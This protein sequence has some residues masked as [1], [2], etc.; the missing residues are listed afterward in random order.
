MR[1]NLSK[2]II[3]LSLLSFSLLLL[4]IFNSCDDT[5]SPDDS[6]FSFVITV[7][8]LN[9]NPIEGIR[10]AAWNYLKLSDGFIIGKRRHIKTKSSATTTIRY[11]LKINSLVSLTIFD[12]ENQVIARLHDE[13]KLIAGL[14]EYN[15]QITVPDPI[16]FYKCIYVAR[17]DTTKE[18]LFSDSI[19]ITLYQPD[20]YASYIGW[21]SSTG[22][23]KTNNIILFP[24]LTKEFKSV[25]HTNQNSYEPLGYAT[26]LDSIRIVLV[27]TISSKWQNVVRNI[28]NGRNE[29]DVIWNP[30]D[31]LPNSVN[32]INE[33]IQS[34]HF[35]RVSKV[36]GVV[37]D[38]PWALYQ[39]YP[40]PY[41]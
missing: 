30:K 8:D 2:R 3:G 27:D 18:I 10:V 32:K 19:Y 39:N 28:H 26:F 14:H 9:G 24:S 40:N 4:I 11:G 22:V 25:V 1:N 16:K 37:Y 21:T 5:L 20:F 41:N 6:G 7:R 15:W 38:F 31:S 34:V 23:F 35:N 29:F 33:A 12:S 13:E 36:T 17:D